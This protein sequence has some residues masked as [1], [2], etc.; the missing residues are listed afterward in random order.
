MLQSKLE[1]KLTNKAPVLCFHLSL[2]LRGRNK[3]NIYQCK[4]RK[5]KY[6]NGKSNCQTT[7]QYH[8]SQKLKLGRGRLELDCIP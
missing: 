3:T 6:K 4:K 2:E 7:N 8:Y 1:F 5:T